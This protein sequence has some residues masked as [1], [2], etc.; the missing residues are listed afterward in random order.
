MSD[1]ERDSRAAA[2]DRRR[3]PIGGPQYAKTRTVEYA[4]TQGKTPD[5]EDVQWREELEEAAQHLRN[6]RT[7]L[8]DGKTLKSTGQLN[9]KE[10]IKP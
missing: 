9:T 7:E 4:K 1:R 5:E 8:R 2:P 6:Q 3:T 10:V